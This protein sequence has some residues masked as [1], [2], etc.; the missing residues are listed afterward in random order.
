M[1]EKNYNKLIGS[2]LKNKTIGRKILIMSLIIVII[3]VIVLGYVAYTSAS[4][5]IYTDIDEKLQ[6]QVNEIENSVSSVYTLSQNKVNADLNVLHKTVYEKGNPSISNDKLVFG[7]NYVINDNYE[8]V[9]EVKQL[10]GGAA[11]IFQKQ[12]DKAVRVSTN[13]VGDDGKRAVGT[14]ASDAVYDEVINKGQTY[15][16]TANVVGN[17]YITAYEPV[18]S[19]AG[20]VIGMLFVGVAEEET[21][22]VIKNQMR[23]I[24]P[25]EN[26]YMLV[27]DSKAEA[28]VHPSK[29]GE[30]IELPILEKIISDKTGIFRYSVDNQE[31]I[32][33]VAYDK[34]LDWYIIATSPLS[35]F[36]G[37][38][39]TM[40]AT[41]VIVVIGGLI[42]AGIL[43]ILFGNSISRRME[44]LVNCA[45]EVRD[46][47][48]S[49][50]ID[51]VGETDEIG[52]LKEA[53]AEVVDT[54]TRFRDEV[55]MVSNHAIAGDL[56]ARGD[57]S[58]FKGDYAVIVDEVNK[59]VDAMAIP[60]HEAIRLSGEYANGNFAARVDPSLEFMGEFVTFKDMLNTIGQDV[61]SALD[62]VK[63]EISELLEDIGNI[64]VNVQTVTDETKYAERSIED[65]SAGVGQVAQI[66]GA[67][68]SLADQSTQSTQQILAAMQDLSVT[69]QSVTTK[70]EQV[71]YL[72]GDA[73]QLSSRGKVV[74]GTAENGMN[75]I[76][77][78]STEIEQMIQ[79][80]S[81]QMVEIGRIVDIISSI[82]EQTNL[83]ALNAAIEA[84]R[85]GDA[86]LG[87]AVVAGE[88]KELAN[89]SQ[90]SAEN[91]AS[92]IHNL[93]SKTDLITSA[94]Q[95]SL[96]EVK[97]GNEAVS[98]TLSL[99]NEIVEYISN[100]NQN[101]NDVAAASQE[102]AASVEEVT[103]TINEFSEM[104]G[105]T[106]QESVGLAAASEESSGA[107]HQIVA[108]VGQVNESMNNIGQNVDKANGSINSVNDAM[109][110][111]SV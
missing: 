39:T 95:G 42:F 29:E 20:D 5:V 109:N 102:Q 30:I 38:I 87:F 34:N 99:F 27:I 79:D 48:L 80:I 84:A 94:V 33:A 85:A 23:S 14:T 8:L 64:A 11:T 31:W 3:P 77:H 89:E 55:S 74:A 100:I 35:D 73:E 32:A 21:L 70:I 44:E 66:A 10:L 28:I 40:G 72:T 88:V 36:T 83:L 107:V 92:I 22:G 37:P 53:F 2:L 103:A 4:S 98:E 82:A 1:G 47:N 91:I 25:S 67:V 105:Q 17:N 46:G 26:G 43:A 41:I 57:A 18:K 9:D 96:S 81:K 97:N 65:V 16:G 93:Q 90:V 71:S 12:G 63:S 106:N 19:S 56:K 62:Q 104:I 59:T 52:I 54:F 68:N 24:K 111:F 108:M 45:N 51:N 58:N 13:V 78:S 60:L 6:L 76:L 15:Y 7:S 49:V 75:D 69:V 86:G 110:R 50:A 61:S 101:M